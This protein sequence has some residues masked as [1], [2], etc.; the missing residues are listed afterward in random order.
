MLSFLVSTSALLLP[1]A[2]R[3]HVCMEAAASAELENP[4]DNFMVFAVAN[5]EK[6]PLSYTVNGKSQ[7]IFYADVKVAMSELETAK[8]QHPDLD[9][10]VVP[11]GLGTAHKMSNEGTA[12]LVPGMRELTAAG[13]PAEFSP[14]GQ[15]LP[16]FA[17]MEMKKETEDGSTVLPLFM[18]FDDCEAAVLEA[19]KVNNDPGLEIV[20]L[21]V[22]SVVDHLSSAA[23]GT[24]P[25]D[26][27][28]PSSSTE[29]L[30]SYIGKGVYYR[31][32]DEE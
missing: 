17:C 27:V 3:A 9:C 11:I 5:E 4:L 13:M 20:G 14:V 21:S 25:F 2:P 28:A 12:T 22:E 18:S 8:A 15:E 7:A 26:F 31:V 29:H 23:D 19:R 16:L 1:S 30:S 6:K 10:D 32:V 24:P